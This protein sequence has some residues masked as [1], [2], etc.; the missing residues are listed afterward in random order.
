MLNHDEQAQMFVSLLQRRKTGSI[1][2]NSELFEA[3]LQWLG[4]PLQ[5]KEAMRQLLCQELCAAT[6]MSLDQLME[7]VQR[8][9]NTRLEKQVA[10]VAE[11]APVNGAA[12]STGIETKLELAR[13]RE[14]KLLRILPEKGFFHDYAQF[15]LESEAPLSYHLYCAVAGVAATVNRRVYMDMG[16]H[17]LFPPFGVFL[18]GSSG[19]KKTSA[20]DI[21]ISLLRESGLTPIYAEKLTPEALID[22]MRGGN[23][24]GVVYAPEMTVLIS[25]QKYMESIIPL[26]T[27]FMDSPDIWNSGTIMRGKAELRDVGITCLMCTT[28]DWFM[29]NTPETLFGGGFIARNI[30]VMEEYSPRIKPLPPAENHQLRRKLLIDLARMYALEGQAHLSS[31]AREAHIDWYHDNKMQAAP[32]TELFETY[33]S[34]KPSHLLRIALCLHVGTHFDIEVCEECWLRALRILEFTEEKFQL[35]GGKM[36]KSPFGED[37]DLILRILEQAGGEITHTQLLRRISYKMGTRSLSV[38][39]AN[40]REMRLVEEFNTAVAHYYKLTKET[41]YG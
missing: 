14:E 29:K 15:T 17:K 33:Y 18:L 1:G 34:R 22:G 12:R 4:L 5:I 2:K 28:I 16:N 26:L 40:L 27:R 3:I 24:T 37:Q 19:I 8:R 35:L 20:G 36:F 39:M 9:T 41:M 23:A 13:Q 10:E 38:I 32:Q 31:E 21:L 30:M 6:G 25:K 7:E 11:A